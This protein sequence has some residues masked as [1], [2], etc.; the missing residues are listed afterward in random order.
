M[1]LRTELTTSSRRLGW[2]SQSAHPP[3]CNMREGDFDG[4]FRVARC[5]PTGM[6][7]R[8]CTNLRQGSLSALA[9][10]PYLKN[11]GSPAC[12]DEPIG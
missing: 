7:S 8:S 2:M 12:A 3:F 5:S 10:Y 11:T 6:E 4:Y 9:I 1:I